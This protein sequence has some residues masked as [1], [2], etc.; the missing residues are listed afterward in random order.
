MPSTLPSNLVSFASILQETFNVASFFLVYTLVPGESSRIKDGQG[1]GSMK[2]LGD[3]L[4]AHETYFHPSNH[5]SW[6]SPLFNFLHCLCEHIY[7]RLL[8]QNSDKYNCPENWKLLPEDLTLISEWLQPLAYL[9]LFGK[10]AWVTHQCQS[11]LRFL[12]C[13]PY[14]DTKEKGSTDAEKGLISSFI[15]SDSPVLS[16]SF[17]PGDCGTQA[18]FP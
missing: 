5:G 8:Y 12:M 14:L 15:H 6:T 13:K 10:D 3:L 2:A 1:T 4:R 7:S 11:I 9:G 18:T 17:F 16:P